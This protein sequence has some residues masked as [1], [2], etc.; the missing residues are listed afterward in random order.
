MNEALE[1]KAQA[2][3]KKGKTEKLQALLGKNKAEK[4]EL[5]ML[6]AGYI[7]TAEASALL[8][9]GLRDADRN[10]RIAAAN[11]LGKIGRLVAEEPLRRQWIN[12]T[13]EG[14]KNIM[15]ENLEKLRANAKR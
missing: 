6:A 2:L 9:I 13:D 11:S 1:K 12:E 15:H 3:G 7:D 10:V 8:V 14:M 4:R 5:A